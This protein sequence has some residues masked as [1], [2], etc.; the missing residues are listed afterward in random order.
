MKFLN[1]SNVLS[2]LAGLAASAA[3]CAVVIGT[4]VASDS[5]T[6]DQTE[7]SAQVPVTPSEG[8]FE[9]AEQENA[10]AGTDSIKPATTGDN[11]ESTEPGSATTGDQDQ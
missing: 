7:E 5:A 11:E 2:F 3:V 1:K 9:P 4:D 10:P 6:Q 8:S